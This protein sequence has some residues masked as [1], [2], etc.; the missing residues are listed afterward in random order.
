MSLIDE[1]RAAAQD[2]DHLWWHDPKAC[3]DL[4][5]L[6]D[7]AD[8]AKEWLEETESG[9]RRLYPYHAPL[10]VKLHDALT[11]VYNNVGNGQ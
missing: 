11:C 9:A 8:A 4:E 5:A 7:I 2:E 6:C 10:W 3:D 1:V